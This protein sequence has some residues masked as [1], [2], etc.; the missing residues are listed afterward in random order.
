[1]VSEAFRGFLVGNRARILKI[2]RI[3]VFALVFG[4]SKL[5]VPLGSVFCWPFRS[6]VFDWCWRGCQVFLEWCLHHACCKDTWQ[7]HRT[8]PMWFNDSFYRSVSHWLNW[9]FCKAFLFWYAFWGDQLQWFWAQFEQIWT[10]NQ[11][12]FSKFCQKH[13]YRCLQLNKL[14]FLRQY[15]LLPRLLSSSIK[16]K[17]LWVHTF[18]WGK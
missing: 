7:Y 2:K 10:L 12:N 17:L 3:S 1:M 5:S 9:H 18:G 16:I 15:C 11:F 4:L 13:K 8:L 14:G 6:E